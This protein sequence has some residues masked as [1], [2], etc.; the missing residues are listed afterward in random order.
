MV[1]KLRRITD[2]NSVFAAVTTDLSKEYDCTTVF[3]LAFDMKS[4]VFVSA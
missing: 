2:K 4:L 3:F 1:G